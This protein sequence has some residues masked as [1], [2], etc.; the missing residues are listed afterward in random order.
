[1]QITYQNVDKLLDHWAKAHVIMHADADYISNTMLTATA[2]EIIAYTRIFYA[3]A[4]LDQG[5]YNAWRQKMLTRAEQIEEMYLMEVHQSLARAQL[6]A[7][8]S[9]AV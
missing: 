5:K 4:D 8:E 2:G 7:K 3:L 1:M 6:A 9:T